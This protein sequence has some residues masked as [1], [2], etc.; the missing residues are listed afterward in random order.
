MG[1]STSQKIEAN[2]VSRAMSQ[3]LTTPRD[4][5]RSSP[6]DRLC[7]GFAFFFGSWTLV[8]NGAVFAGASLRQLEAAYVAVA[9]ACSVGATTW[10][11]RR[12]R[13]SRE[14]GATGVPRAKGSDCRDDRAPA[15]WQR[16]AVAAAALVSLGLYAATGDFRILWLSAVPW[17]FALCL[18]ELSSKPAW[19][20]PDPSSEGCEAADPRDHRALLLSLALV[21]SVLTLVVHRPDTDDAFYV[22]M[23]VAAADH[24]SAPLLTGDTVHGVAGVPLPIPI[25]KVHS[26]ELLSASLSHLTRLPVL[27]IAHL[28]LPAVVAFLVP[29]A[30]ARLLRLLMPRA[31][32]WGVFFAMAFLLLAG[33][34]THGH[35]NFAFVRLHQGKSMLLSLALPLIT[36]YAMEFALAPSTGRWLRLAAAQITA[37]GLSASGLWLAPAVAG[38]ALASASAPRRAAIRTLIIGVAA[39][40]YPL[41][42]GLGLQADTVA[43]FRDAAVPAVRGALDNDALIA[44]AIWAGLG[45]DPASWLALFAALGAWCVAPSALARRCCVLFPLAFLLLFLNPYTASWTASH[46][47]S[48]PTYWRVFWLLPLPVLVAVLL[49]ALL[50]RPEWRERRWKAPCLSLVATAAVLLWAP[51]THTLSSVN[52]V[53]LDWPGWK[54]PP[55]ILDAARTAAE[56][57]QPG[58]AVLAP[59]VVAPWIPT[60]HQHPQPIVVRIEYLPLLSGHL[61][62]QELTRRVQLI[63]LVSGE[64]RPPHADALLEEA[65][66]EYPLEV[67]V[68]SRE[69]LRWSDLPRTLERAGL[70]RVKSGKDFEVW[71]RRSA[72]RTDP[73]D[74]GP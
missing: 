1:S 7:D 32:L 61:D 27:S 49:G 29:L 46:V 65:I 68:L 15:P 69:A 31:W 66:R 70:A 9:V 50:A 42:L 47:T 33:G 51:A 60:L 14:A 59:R 11:R 12:A 6:A 54:I 26:L 24:P 53:R 73:E 41:A 22:N 2:G 16:L 30:Y 43:A 55:T 5:D 57:A 8:A 3:R 71:A 44:E 38:L 17:L 40:A 19:P 13:K 28:W 58:A 4:P 72:G 36:A 25:Y 62:E 63:R 67:V 23:A 34:A 52:R 48:V 35:G 39:S 45:R 37:V 20:R 10:L 56:H 74:P 21:C 64:S 18:R